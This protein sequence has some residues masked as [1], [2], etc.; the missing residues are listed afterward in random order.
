MAVATTSGEIEPCEDDAICR[1]CLDRGDEPLRSFCSCR[2]TQRW[3]HLTCL[4]AWQ[5]SVQTLSNHPTDVASEERHLVCNACKESFVGVPPPS[6]SE[7]LTGLARLELD[8][9]QV[10]TLLRYADLVPLPQVEDPAMQVLFDSKQRHFQGSVYLLTM[11]DRGVAEDG[12]DD[13]L[14]GVNLTREAA[15]TW[16]EWDP[17]TLSERT[18]GALSDDEVEG[19]RRDGIRVE[20]GLGGP[21]AP[22]KPEWAL[23]ISA[24]EPGGWNCGEFRTMARRA[25]SA[26][27]RA[28]RRGDEGASSSV[29]LRIFFGKAR[30]TRLQLL[31]EVARGSWGV[32]SSGPRLADLH[33]ERGHCRGSGGL[34]GTLGEE[35]PS[36][37]HWAPTN[38]MRDEFY[39]R[40]SVRP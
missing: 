8:A 17:S 19:W 18:R 15:E 30:W 31:G 21:V 33:A 11:V 27:S 39:R 35:D 1:F 9:L 4:K 28:R 16:A 2:G 26:A 36:R 6:R 13:V 38:S 14:F 12:A 10:S 22:K 24:S 3:L 25:V 29:E 40:R 20:L 32:V 7:I 37:L 34:W 5:I 23:L